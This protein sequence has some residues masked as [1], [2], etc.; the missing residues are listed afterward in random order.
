MSWQKAMLVWC[1]IIAAPCLVSILW[2]KFCRHQDILPAPD[3]NCL[4]NGP[5]ACPDL[6]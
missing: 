1:A 4:R 5:E 6:E 2:G 3:R